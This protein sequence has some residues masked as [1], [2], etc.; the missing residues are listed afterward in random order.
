MIFYVKILPENSTLA[1][2]FFDLLLGHGRTRT[3]SADFKIPCTRRFIGKHKIFKFLSQC[4]L[5]Y[6][7]VVVYGAGETQRE[8]LIQPVAN[9]VWLCVHNCTQSEIKTKNL[10]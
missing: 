5:K 2:D 6:V 7:I 9:I 4:V 3:V 1:N 10:V 8:F